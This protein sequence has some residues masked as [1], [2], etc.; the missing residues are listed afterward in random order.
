MPTYVYHCPANAQTVEVRH[1]M[2]E[3]LTRWDELCERADQPPG[4]TPPDAPVERQLTAPAVVASTAP[5][6]DACPCGMP[7]GGCGMQ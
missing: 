2:N 4:T 3:T 1:G 7:G 5:V 6:P